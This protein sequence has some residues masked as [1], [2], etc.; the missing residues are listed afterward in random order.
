MPDRRSN[1]RGR[2][3]VLTRE[4]IFESVWGNEH[5]GESNIIDVN[6]RALRE[7][8]ETDHLSRLIQTVRGFGYALREA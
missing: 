4:A 6:V 2:P 5:M 7:K 3:P 8:L 1:R